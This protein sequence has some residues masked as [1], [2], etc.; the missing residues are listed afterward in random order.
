M[1]KAHGIAVLALS[2]S[3]TAAFAGPPLG[4]DFAMKQIARPGSWVEA[5]GTL[6]PDG[7]LMGKDFEIYAPADSLG[8]D[9][10]IYG[11][12]QDINRVKSTMKVLGYVVTWDDKTT[13]KDELKR[14]IMSSKMEDGMAVKVQGSVQAN[15]SFKATKFRVT[16][17]KLPGGK[18]AK[19]K[20]YG[21]ATLI[22]AKNGVMRILNTTV[23]LRQ[24]AVLV[25]AAPNP[26]VR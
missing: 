14:Q 15:G 23:T 19:E 17:V 16:T 1:S 5:D 11:A 22:D 7:T 20:V 4:R 8:E 2:L 12:I 25:E 13:I 9:R 18:K 24:D 10:A 6:M 26:L 3:A 21:P